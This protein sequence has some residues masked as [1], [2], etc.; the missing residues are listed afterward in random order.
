MFIKIRKSHFKR[1][2]RL[3]TFEAKSKKDK[4][5]E[6]IFCE[7]LD[8]SYKKLSYFSATKFL[9]EPKRLAP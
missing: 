8:I 1:D 5:S 3:K 2:R 4:K 7:K 6:K 9:K